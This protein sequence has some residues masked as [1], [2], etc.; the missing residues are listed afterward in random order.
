MLAAYRT[1]LPPD[2]L[3]RWLGFE[4]T[5]AGAGERTD[6]GEGDRAARL[7]EEARAWLEGQGCKLCEDGSLDVAACRLAQ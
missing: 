4:Q 6:E 3:V 5:D 7:R 1:P 2:M